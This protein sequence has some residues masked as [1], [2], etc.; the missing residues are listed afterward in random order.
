[1]LNHCEITVVIAQ[2]LGFVLQKGEKKEDRDILVPCE[3][4]LQ[5]GTKYQM[6]CNTPN[7]SKLQE[8]RKGAEDERRT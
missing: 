3:L 7:S 5:R 4:V 2:L 6:L 8:R 1:M